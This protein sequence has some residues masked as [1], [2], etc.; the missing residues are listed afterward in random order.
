MF[1]S[2]SMISRKGGFKEMGRN[3]QRISLLWE[4]LASYEE[5]KAILL[6]EVSG[7]LKCA[8]V[9]IIGGEGNIASFHL[10]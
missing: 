2:M 1:G 10:K 9:F 7:F 8:D 5:R 6:A 3:F 4:H